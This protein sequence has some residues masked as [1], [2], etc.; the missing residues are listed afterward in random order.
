M[1][2]LAAIVLALVAVLLA[3]APAR[4]GAKNE[5]QVLALSSADAFDNAQALT[6]ALKRVI[7]RG[8]RFSLAPGDFS[9]EVLS[10]LL[11][12][13]EVPDEE[14]LLKI[15]KKIESERYVWGTVE[16]SGEQVV[17]RLNV[18]ENGRARGETQ[19][20]YSASLTDP[21]DETLLG[22]ADSAMNRLIA[23]VESKLFV[24]SKAIDGEVYVNGAKAGKL[25]H[26][27]A[28]LKVPSGA[29]E[30]ELRAPGFRPAR[31]KVKVAAGETAELTLEP[32]PDDGGDFDSVPR[33]E[34][35]R[36]HGRRILGF[37]T[38]G[39]GTVV[40]GVGA[41]FWV[42]TAQQKEDDI[43]REYRATVSE[44][45]DP[46]V[47]AELEGRREI[48]EHCDANKQ[49]RMA[50]RILVPSGLV[51]AGIGTVLLA[52]DK[53]RS[54]E[55]VSLGKARKTSSLVLKPV[56]GPRGGRLDVRVS[57]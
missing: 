53:S 10:A 35:S 29:L 57:F 38:L 4:A 25:S 41:A 12:C 13:P 2:Q 39:I 45:Q 49:A 26:G 15:S 43:W 30:V 40:A 9:L 56:F 18:W 33:G 1:K 21:S 50:A 19:L 27:R 14:C 54:G 52:T 55:H 32:V 36:G 44:D 22:L 24:R 23:A 51:I 31:G 48:V 20:E 46:C 28:E 16:K 17:A 34:T 6:V 5:V 11:N 42:Q 8:E 7:A 37:S 47:Q 3:A